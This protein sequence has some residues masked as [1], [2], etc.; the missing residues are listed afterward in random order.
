MDG[1]LFSLL[2]CLALLTGCI[3][4]QP[5]DKEF[6]A[7]FEESDTNLGDLFASG[8]FPKEYG[9]PIVDYCGSTFGPRELIGEVEEEWFPRQLMAGREPSLYLLSQQEPGPEFVLRF[10]YIPSFSPSI[11]V[12][13]YADDGGY[14]L[15]AKKLSGV[16][17]YE[18]GTIAS[19][20]KIRLPPDE[21]AELERLLATGALFEEQQESCELGFVGSDWLFEQVDAS[22]YKL[23]KRWSPSSGAGYELGQHLLRLSGYR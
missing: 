23:V 11:F 15:V 22:G 20:K 13:I 9:D 2:V 10:S 17:G 5:Y 6:E 18:P 1:K 4:A 3:P 19:S 7:Q 8:Y 16:G 21:V 12:R 14:V